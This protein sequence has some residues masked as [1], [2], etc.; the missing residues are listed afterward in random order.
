MLL[1]GSDQT[2]AGT[3]DR[4]PTG[5]SEQRMRYPCSYAGGLLFIAAYERSA[6]G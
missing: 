2:I 6:L 4:A 5:I 1:S 3:I